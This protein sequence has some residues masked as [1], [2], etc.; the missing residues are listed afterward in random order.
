MMPDHMYDPRGSLWRRWDLHVHTPASGLNNHFACDWDEYAKALFTKAVQKKIAVIGVTDYFSIEGYRKIRAC[1]VND[2][3]LEHLLKEEIAADPTLL[4]TVKQ[5][6]VL[7]N[8]ELR[9]TALVPTKGDSRHRRINL[10]VIFS[11]DVDPQ[12]IEE[13]FLNRLEFVVEGFPDGK[14]DTKTLTRAN[15][16]KLGRRLKMEQGFRE[17]DFEVGCGHLAINHDSVTDLLEN[18][19]RTFGNRYILVLADEDVQRVSFEGQG[20]LTRKVLY[21]KA[22]FLFTA[23][24]GTRDHLLEEDF[25]DEFGDRKPCIWGCDAHSL[26]R[27]FEVDLNRYCWIKADRTFKGLLQVTNEPV[28]RVF[29][30]LEPPTV[31]SI[32]ERRRQYIQSINISKHDPSFAERWFDNTKLELNPELIA[33]I[34][35]RGAAKA[36]WLTSSR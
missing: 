36:R 22:H 31:V 29:I 10:H 13:N 2:A 24:P 17:S 7:P 19:K 18:Q 27:L 23:N 15:I 6:V 12:D 32:R 20:H 16:E 8:V 3:K 9:L 4:A 30:G 14:D 11:E 25:A 34:G 26:D 33:I 35:R 5:L 21:Q 28:D 1:L